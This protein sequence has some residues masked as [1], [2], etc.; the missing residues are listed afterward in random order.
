MGS[1]GL[2]TEILHETVYVMEAGDPPL[3]RWA[4]GSSGHVGLRQ[5]A[6]QGLICAAYVGTTL[7]VWTVIGWEADS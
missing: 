4:V 2:F 5:T 6:Q 3:E 7:L 1:D